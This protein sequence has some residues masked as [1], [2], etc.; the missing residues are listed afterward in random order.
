V[1]SALRALDHFLAAAQHDRVPPDPRLA[2]AV[3]VVRADRDAAGR[4]VQEL[5]HP[6]RAWF[7]VDVPP[8]EPSKWLTLSALRVLDWWDSAAV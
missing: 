2:E 1:Y 3:E 7:E 4:R 5:R 8:G 6:G